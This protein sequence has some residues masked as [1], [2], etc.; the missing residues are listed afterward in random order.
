MGIIPKQASFRSPWQNGACERFIKT[1][2]R[3]LLDHVIVLDEQHL[4]RFLKGY[5]GYYHKESDSPCAA[6]HPCD[7]VLEGQ[8]TYVEVVWR[9]ASRATLG[10]KPKS[11]K[12]LPQT[13]FR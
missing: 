13:I 8:G 1:L 3:E 12:M 9:Q 4:M 2:R 11:R 6:L 7:E 5:L 10:T